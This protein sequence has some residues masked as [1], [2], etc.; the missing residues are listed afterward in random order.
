M[1]YPP[2]VWNRRKTPFRCCHLQWFQVSAS[3]NG[4][5][6]WQQR[7]RNQ[8]LA[9]AINNLHRSF[10]TKVTLQWIPGRSNVAGNER[11]DHL[12]KEGTKG[13]QPNRP[14][15]QETFKQILKN[16]TKEEWLNRWTTGMTVRVMYSEMNKPKPNDTINT[17]S[18]RPMHHLSTQTRTWKAEPLLEPAWCILSTALPKLSVS[19]TTKH[20]LLECPG[21]IAARK[22]L[23]PTPPTIQNILYGT[24]TQLLNTDL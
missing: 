19:L 22:N 10:K 17:M 4:K 18:C 13:L 5:F 24:R 9:T 3:G 7:E 15:N 23:L 14:L 8:S 11:A 1:N 20:V 2:T 21:L 12:A 6:V 16:T